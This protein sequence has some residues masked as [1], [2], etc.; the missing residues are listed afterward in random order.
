ML[1]QPGGA[2]DGGEG[3]AARVHQRGGLPYRAEVRVGHGDIGYVLDRSR[4]G[5]AFPFSTASELPTG[6]VVRV[7]GPY[8]DMIRRAAGEAL[9]DIGRSFNVSHSTISRL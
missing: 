9:A 7:N 2:A 3:G 8:S 6:S 1:P 5:S 4:F